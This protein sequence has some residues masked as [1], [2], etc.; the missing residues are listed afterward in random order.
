MTQLDVVAAGML[1]RVERDGASHEPSSC[2][3]RSA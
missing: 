1:A 2:R 3:S